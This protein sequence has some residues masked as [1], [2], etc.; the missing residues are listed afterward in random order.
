[1]LNL[2]VAPLGRY[3]TAIPADEDGE[4]IP[5]E[6]SAAADTTKA[7]S[8]TAKLKGKTAE[9]S[10]PVPAMR[11]E[12]HKLRLVELTLPMAQWVQLDAPGFLPNRRQHRMFGLSVLQMGA[13]L[14]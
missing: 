9:P 1:M 13:A 12:A 14:T 3:S 4:L 8:A 11:D 10:V 7:G 6:T 5:I 2:G